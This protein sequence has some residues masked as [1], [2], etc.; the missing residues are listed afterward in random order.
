ML[1]ASFVRYIFVQLQVTEDFSKLTALQIKMKK[2]SYNFA[3]TRIT[4]VFLVGLRY[5]FLRVGR[6]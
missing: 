4:L 6:K 1:L 3:E 5:I 2:I